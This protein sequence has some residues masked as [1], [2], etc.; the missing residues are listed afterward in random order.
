MNP[1]HRIKIVIR[2]IGLELPGSAEGVLSIDFGDDAHFKA[3]LKKLETGLVNP[4]QQSVILENDRGEML[5]FNPNHYS[6][7]T[8]PVEDFGV[9]RPVGCVWLLPAKPAPRTR[10]Q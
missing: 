7:H 9:W 1:K 10:R 2:N 5:G 6:Y 3:A 8:V 4:L